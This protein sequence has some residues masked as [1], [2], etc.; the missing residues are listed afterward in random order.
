MYDVFSRNRGRHCTAVVL[1][2][3][4]GPVPGH[5]HGSDDVCGDG[6]GVETE[7]DAEVRAGRGR[8]PFAA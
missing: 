3:E 7:G 5:H 6:D 8:S 2:G 4:G 1:S